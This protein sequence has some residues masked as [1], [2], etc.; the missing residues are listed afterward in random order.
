MKTLTR[1]DLSD[2][3]NGAAIL[4]AGGGGDLREGFGMIDHA[5]DAGKSF[6]LVS[7]DD[8]P[9]D[10]IICT[11]Y[12][13]GAISA[14]TE[15]EERGYRH[16]PKAS[17]HPILTAY[18]KFQEYLGTTFY[19]TTACELGGSNT[20]AAF[21]PAAMN[22][23]YIVDADPAGRAVPEITHSTYYLAGLPAAPIYTANEFGETF[24]LE[25]VHDDQRAETLV[26][27]LSTVSRHD[28]AAID[29]ALP[30]RELRGALIAGTI[31]KA[32]N[33][34]KAWREAKAASEDAI[35][36]VAQTGSG[37]V[38][39]E[40]VV[41]TCV[42]ETVDG[43]TIGAMNI[44]GTGPNQGQTMRI[45]V[46]NEN[47]ACWLNGKT[48]ATVPDLIC[49]FDAETQDQISNPDCRV[50]QSVKVVLL[51]A[52]AVFRTEKGLSIFGPEYA[53]I[54]QPYTWPGAA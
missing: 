36:R 9:D 24:V 6:Q 16:L 38:G 18:D 29:H 3:L 14:L 48:Y 25:G 37:F 2:I 53:G 26:R 1:Q 44:D 50:D 10:A 35:A 41:K 30:M 23:H 51:P 45:S 54:D 32:M 27:A 43:F 40:G 17:Q 5:L 31:T 28:I 4:G 21:F 46:K 47:M 22:G 52:P 13:L 8:V 12:M 11:P 20:A 42:Y 49:L 33:L 15:E 19:G 7:V 39:F 34:G